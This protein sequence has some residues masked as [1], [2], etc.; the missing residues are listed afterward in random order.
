MKGVIGDFLL[1]VA[2]NCLLC[3]VENNPFFFYS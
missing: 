3:V 1:F 2:V